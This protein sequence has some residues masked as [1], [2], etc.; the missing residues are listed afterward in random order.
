LKISEKEIEDWG[1][2]N[3]YSLERQ[4]SPKSVKVIKGRASMVGLGKYRAFITH[5]GTAAGTPLTGDLSD[6]ERAICIPSASRDTTNVQIAPFASVDSK[7]GFTID[8]NVVESN[9]SVAVLGGSTVGLE[10]SAV[11][12]IVNYILIYYEF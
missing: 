9:L 3:F 5:D 4:E 6:D 2:D 11:P 7:S 1:L 10:F 12:L 8:I